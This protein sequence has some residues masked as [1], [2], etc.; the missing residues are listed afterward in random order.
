MW[1]TL[2]A[3]KTHD[4]K[5]IKSSPYKCIVAGDF[6]DTPNSY[7]VSKMSKILKDSFLESGSKTGKTYKDLI[8]PLRID[9]I[10]IDNELISSSFKT[11]NKT[12]LSDH[13]PISTDLKN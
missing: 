7:S 10:F 6:N 3:S 8:I 2:E 5:H 11:Y 12:F 9:Y 1:Y 4:I 13:Y